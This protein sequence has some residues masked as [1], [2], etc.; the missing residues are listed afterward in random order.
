MIALVTTGLASLILLGLA[1][2]AADAGGHQP[3]GIHPDREPPQPRRI[4]LPTAPG[5]VA[6]ARLSV[7]AGRELPAW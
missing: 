7:L 4:R 3:A 2:G 6:K 5:V 1:I